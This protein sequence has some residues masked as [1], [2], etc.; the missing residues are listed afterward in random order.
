M[1]VRVYDVTYAEIQFSHL[2]LRFVKKWIKTVK[3]L[4]FL[5]INLTVKY[6]DLLMVKFINGKF[7]KELMKKQKKP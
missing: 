5:F 3:L 6:K 7:N 2:K 1:F 4:S